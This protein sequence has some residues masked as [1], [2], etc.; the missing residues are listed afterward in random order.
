MPQP[1]PSGVE[2]NRYWQRELGH[3][4]AKGKGSG[5]YLDFGGDRWR[6]DRKAEAGKPVR[7]SWKSLKAKKGESSTGTSQRQQRI[8]NTSLDPKAQSA[9]GKFATQPGPVHHA[10]AAT[11][12]G[13]MLEQFELNNNPN[14]KPTDG[15][16]T[17]GKAFLRALQN[18]L[19]LP[20][21]DSPLNHRYYPAD[22][23]STPG[24]SSVHTEAHRLQRQLGI[25]PEQDLSGY[26]NT[27]L[28]RL[29]QK[30]A[31][32]VAEIDAQLGYK[33]KFKSPGHAGAVL[34]GV[35]LSDNLNLRY[36]E[37]DPELESILRGTPQETPNLPSQT[38]PMT[39]PLG[40]NMPL[41]GFVTDT[42]LP[43]IQPEPKENLSPQV[44]ETNGETNGTNGYTNVTNGDNNGTNGYSNGTSGDNNGTNG[45]GNGGYAEGIAQSAK[46]FGEFAVMAGVGAIGFTLTTLEQLDPA[47]GH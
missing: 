3:W 2:A 26:S 44:M 13:K 32:G 14:W 8:A 45:Y 39:T 37:R 36:I 27:E 7:F 6:L 18:R 23:S 31:K 17:A 19:A 28:W 15:P 42:K 38:P 25:N 41:G 5:T 40:V 4:Q 24:V 10:A 11:L 29:A 22:N 16:S 46:L 35:Q 21:G 1:R 43:D 34:R 33:P 30:T 47:R 9:F 20:T 12:V